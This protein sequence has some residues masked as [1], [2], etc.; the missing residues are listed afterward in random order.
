MCLV[1][2]TQYV[3]AAFPV[4]YYMHI[5]CLA[6]YGTFIYFFM[7]TVYIIY[8]IIYPVVLYF[9]EFSIE[10]ESNWTF[11]FIEYRILQCFRCFDREPDV[12][13]Y[14]INKKSKFF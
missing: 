7:A 3:Y 6:Y 8:I 5:M 14:L 9:Y 10:L 12:G 11:I 2:H 1:S 4:P 13:V